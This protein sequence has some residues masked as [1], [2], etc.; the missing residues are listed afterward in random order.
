[1]RFLPSRWLSQSLI[2][3]AQ[4]R[5]RR[6]LASLAALG[7]PALFVSLACSSS[8][9]PSPPPKVGTP[10]CENNPGGYILCSDSKWHCCG[11]G[12]LLQCPPDA[13]PLGPC[14]GGESCFLSCSPVAGTDV[15]HGVLLACQRIISPSNYTGVFHVSCV[16]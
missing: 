12:G 13:R 8:S 3:V 5:S 16:P 14:I 15:G 1:M 4:S 6:G 11:L 9:P 10:E 7:I 2:A